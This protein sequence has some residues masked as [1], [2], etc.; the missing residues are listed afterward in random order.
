MCQSLQNIHAAKY[1]YAASG[2][3]V[4]KQTNITP[5]DVGSFLS[6]C[7]CFA[8]RFRQ[9]KKESSKLPIIYFSLT[10]VLIFTS[11]TTSSGEH[12]CGLPHFINEP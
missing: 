12:Q 10:S 11:L 7:N 5:K 4:F 8:A 2:T 3:L 6:G 9:H 1:A